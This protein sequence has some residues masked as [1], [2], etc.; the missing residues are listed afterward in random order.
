[1]LKVKTRNIVADSQQPRKEFDERELKY[2]QSS[3]RRYGIVT[4]LVVEDIGDGTYLL[5]DGE[6]RYRAAMAEGLE[7]VPVVIDSNVTPLDRKVK[8]F[9]IQRQHAQW[10]PLEEAS[11]VY[12]LSEKYNIPAHQM[13]DLLSVD[14]ERMRDYLSLANLVNRDEFV[15]NNISVRWATQ[16]NRVIKAAKKIYESQDKVF[17]PQ[18]QQAIESSF[19]G[20]IK[21]GELHTSKTPYTRIIDAFMKDPQTI[22]KFMD[23]AISVDELFIT[24]KAKSVYHLRNA[25]MSAGYVRSHLAEFFRSPDVEVPDEWLYDFKAAHRELETLLAKI[26]R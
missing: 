9:H 15:K 19:I 14:Q 23:P 20:R 10:T 6:R 5:V 8:Q 1:M 18:V 3:I 24:S 16:L 21:S 7:E 13:A 4:P 25:R 2:L 26:D 11:V 22:E 12:E 17:S